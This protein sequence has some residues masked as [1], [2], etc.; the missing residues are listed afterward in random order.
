MKPDSN[1]LEENGFSK[2]LSTPIQLKAV[3]EDIENNSKEMESI[4]LMQK[5]YS[6]VRRLF[7]LFWVWFILVSEWYAVLTC[8]LRFV[9][10]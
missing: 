3:A 5:N 1:G 6:L 7:Q 2:T 9:E 4:W 10:S 8:L